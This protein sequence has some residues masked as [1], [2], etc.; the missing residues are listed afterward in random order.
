MKEELTQT[1]KEKIDASLAK[2]YSM[3]KKFETA[4]KMMQAEY[5]ECV[6]AVE[7]VAKDLKKVVKN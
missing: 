7:K 6:K 1:Q 2:L 4:V 5:D 3:Q